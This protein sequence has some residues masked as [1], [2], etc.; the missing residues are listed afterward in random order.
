[1][2]VTIKRPSQLDGNQTLQGAFN[3]VDNTHT[4]NGFLTSKVGRRVEIAN[5]TTTI[6]NDTQVITFIEDGVTLYVFTLIYTDGSQD[7]M[8]SAERTA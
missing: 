5:S 8:M 2:P 3:D 7:T 4:V 1:M 6:L